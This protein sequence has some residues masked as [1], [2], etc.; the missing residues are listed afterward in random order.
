MWPDIR[1]PDTWP[2]E[3]KLTSGPVSPEA[4]KTREKERNRK[5][6]VGIESPSGGGGGIRAEVK[7]RSSDDP[8][9]S[10]LY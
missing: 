4:S 10:R 7:T 9:T 6:S 1:G 8:Y 2:R 5:R 3:A